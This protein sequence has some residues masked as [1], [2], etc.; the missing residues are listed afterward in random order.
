VEIA[1]TEEGTVLLDEP[2][3]PDAL[4]GPDESDQRSRR[5]RVPAVRSV[6]D[7]RPAIARLIGAVAAR[8]AR[9]QHHEI[10]VREPHGRL[11]PRGQ[12]PAELRGERARPVKAGRQRRDRVL[13]RLDEERVAA[14]ELQILDRTPEQAYAYIRRAPSST[15]KQWQKLDIQID[16]FE[17]TTAPNHAKLVNALFNACRANG[18]IYKGAYTGLYAVV[19]ESFVTDAKPG[20]ID[21]DEVF[22]KQRARWLHTGGI[23]C[24][25]SPTAPEVALEAMQA[26]KRHRTV[27]SYDLNYRASLW[28]SNGGKKQA[29]EVN[30]RIA[31][32]VNVMLG[33]E[34]DFSAALGQM[35]DMA[36]GFALL[37]FDGTLQG[38]HLLETLQGGVEHLVVHWYR[39]A[40]NALNVLLDLVAMLGLGLQHCQDENFCVH[41]AYSLIYVT[42]T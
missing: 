41:M 10:P 15:P 21:W 16:R 42:I 5:L 28:K 38:A 4:E 40:Q 7:P 3:E 13:R 14:D 34:E 18:Y 19:S 39:A 35:V 2:D 25:L 30:R 37:P 6:P 27:V 22:G 33:N 11:Q 17:R 29:Q 36:V 8:L 20:D 32:Y 9:D 26:A 12:Q 31:P 24:A 23:F 1:P